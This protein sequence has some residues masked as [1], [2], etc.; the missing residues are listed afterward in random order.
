MYLDFLPLCRVVSAVT[1]CQGILSA[2][3]KSLVVSSAPVPDV[4]KAMTFDPTEKYE[5]KKMAEHSIISLLDGSK[6]LTFVNPLPQTAKQ[7]VT[8]MVDSHTVT[9]SV[10]ATALICCGAL[11]TKCL[12]CAL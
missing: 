1:A 7:I 3:M 9:V 6:V 2:A 8:V 4:V 10:A 12:Q 5:V 11:F